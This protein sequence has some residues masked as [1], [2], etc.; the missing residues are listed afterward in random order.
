VVLDEPLSMLDTAAAVETIA[1]LE[2][3]RADG[4]AVVACEHRRAHFSRLRCEVHE[5]PAEETDERPLPEVEP[6]IPAFRLVAAG[7]AVELGGA[8]VLD[9]IDLELRGGEV[10]AVVGAN[11]AGKTTL[12]RTLAGLQTHRGRLTGYRSGSARAP[13]LGLC[14]HNPDRQIFNPSVREEIVYGIPVVDERAYRNVIDL[15]GLARYE[16]VPPLLLSEG[17]KKRLALAIMLLRPG[18]CGICLDEP[19]LGQD[20]RNRRLLGAIVRRLAAAGYLCLIATH[21]LQWAAE[22]ADRMLLLHGGRISA[23]G[24]PQTALDSPQLWMHAGL[25]LPEGVTQRC[26]RARRSL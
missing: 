1:H 13:H 20:D 23:G 12:L 24:K 2:R 10:I 17:E 22:W 14:F 4:T 6:K 21:D 18:L 8:R 9:G 7:L 26:E 19:T 15:L 25:P 5:L 16:H 11:G 3:R